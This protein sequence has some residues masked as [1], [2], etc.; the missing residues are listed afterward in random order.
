[1]NRVAMS[2]WQW[3][4]MCMLMLLLGFAGGYIHKSI[5]NVDELKERWECDT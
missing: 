3:V 1:M 5:A 4:V 2:F